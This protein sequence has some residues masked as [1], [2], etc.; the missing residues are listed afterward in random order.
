MSKTKIRTAGFTLIELLVVIVIIGLLVGIAV[1]AYQKAKTKARETQSVANM[2]TV[3]E[4]VERFGVDYN[5]FYPYRL[6]YYST[7]GSNANPIVD[8]APGWPPMGLVGGVRFMAPDGHFYSASELKNNPTLPLDSVKGEPQPHIGALNQYFHNYSDPLFAL[9]YLPS[10]YP[11][12]PFMGRPIGMIDWGWS[13]DGMYIPGPSVVVSPGDMVYTH[14]STFDPVTNAF[15]EPKGVLVDKIRYRAEDET[16]QLP[17][18][19]SLD[20]IDSYQLWVYGDLPVMNLHWSAYDNSEYPGPPP[21][22]VAIKQDWNGNG[23]TDP[24]EAG[25]IGYSS[26]GAASSERDKTTGGKI[27]Y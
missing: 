15:Q 2:K 14:F 17:G 11:K 27:E 20:L 3:Q 22:K 26:G 23:V 4:A 18:E 12:N 19:W 10:G 9:G 1:P 5:G 8:Q 21:R 24:F 13:T 25:L 6:S 7:V 16:G